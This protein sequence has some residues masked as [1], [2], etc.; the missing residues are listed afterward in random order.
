M[1]RAI[2]IASISLLF[3]SGVQADVLVDQEPLSSPE[4]GYF[5][6]AGEGGFSCMA[7][8]GSSRSDDPLADC[9]ELGGLKIGGLEGEAAILV[10]A[11]IAHVDGGDG[12]VQIHAL[13]WAGTPN[14]SDLT[15]YI[16]VA[17]DSERRTT[18]I[19]LSGSL[20]PPCCWRFSGLTVGDSTDA[21]IARFG[22]PFSVE[23][24]P[25]NG[26]TLWLYGPWPFS[27]EVLDGKVSSIRI[28]ANQL[29][30]MNE[31]PAARPSRAE[32][33]TEIPRGRREL[34]D[35]IARTALDSYQSCVLRSAERLERSR[36]TADIVAASAVQSCQEARAEMLRIAAG[37]DWRYASVLGRAVD[38]RVLAIAQARVVAIRS[39]R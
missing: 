9:L 34:D 16:A 26:A 13:S 21:L 35:P 28:V 31:E 25:A 1:K 19:Q 32:T 20:P 4:L 2:V 12:V 3:C 39:R 29:A 15:S 23:A 11:P 38:E 14:A 7:R 18:S 22:R 37:T 17:Y 6:R 8:S 33:G 27:F 5:S 36:E 10:G 30:G 24:V